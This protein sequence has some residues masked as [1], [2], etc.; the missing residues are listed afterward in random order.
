VP[1]ARQAAQVQQPTAT[2]PPHA[3]GGSG[4]RRKLGTPP[5]PATRP[6]PK[7]DQ[8][9]RPHPSTEPAPAQPSLAGQ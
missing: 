1:F 9:A 8:A 5:D 7:P 3:P 4:R 6:D 2:P